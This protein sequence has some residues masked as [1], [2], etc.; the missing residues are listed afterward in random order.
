M[1]SNLIRLRRILSH[2]ILPSLASPVTQL[3][4]CYLRTGI[5][6]YATHMCGTVTMVRAG[7]RAVIWFLFWGAIITK[8]SPKPNKRDSASG[9]HHQH[10]QQPDF[11]FTFVVSLV[12]CIVKLGQLDHLLKTF[13]LNSSLTQA[14]DRHILIDFSQIAHLFEH[15]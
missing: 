5:Q 8:T 9:S 11:T 15:T 1:L 3:G 6:Q 10:R 14:V 4:Q 12:V 2:G 7:G 13:F